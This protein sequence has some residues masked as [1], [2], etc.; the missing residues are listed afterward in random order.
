MLPARRDTERS[1]LRSPE[2]FV[3]SSNSWIA[4]GRRKRLKRGRAKVADSAPCAY[5]TP[6][7]SAMRG[8]RRLMQSFGAGDGDDGVG[9]AEARD[10]G[11]KFG[12]GSNGGRRAADELGTSR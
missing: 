7:E 8:S 3:T 11:W 9:G 4:R 5:T 10:E 12:R 2:E 1:R 6:V